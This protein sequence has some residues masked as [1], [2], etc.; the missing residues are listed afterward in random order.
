MT[1]IIQMNL[2]AISTEEAFIINKAPTDGRELK[3]TVSRKCI[4]QNEVT[5]NYIGLCSAEIR[6]TDELELDLLDTSF[7]V[8]VVLSGKLSCPDSISD[9]SHEELTEAALFQMFPHI[10][11]TMAALMSSAGIAPYLIPSSGII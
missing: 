1:N 5:G 2:N 6:F 7:L 11:A 10:R 4:P 3:L 9:Y 8:R